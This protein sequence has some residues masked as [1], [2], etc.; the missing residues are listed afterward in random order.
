M[1]IKKILALTIIV[2]VLFYA[3]LSFMN[4]IGMLGGK[5]SGS[6]EIRL[7]QLLK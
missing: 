2:L 1:N 7:E 4:K 6:K 5:I 3:A